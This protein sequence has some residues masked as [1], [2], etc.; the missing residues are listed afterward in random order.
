MPFTA[1]RE[2]LTEEVQ[3]EKAELS[4]LRPGEVSVMPLL[5]NPDSIRLLFCGWQVTL[6]PDGTWDWEDTT[7]G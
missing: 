4:R 5:E 1:L 3:R 6:R 7:G 2:V